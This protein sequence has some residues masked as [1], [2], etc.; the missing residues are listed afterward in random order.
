MKSLAS[1]VLLGVCGVW[2]SAR[3]LSAQCPDGT[4]PPCSVRPVRAAPAPTSVAVLPFANLSRDSSDAYLAEGLTEE[5]IS[6]LG[7]V[8]RLRVPGRSV[9]ERA[10]AADADPQSLA[11]RLGVRYLV[12]GSVRRSGRRLRVSVR[13]L[14]ALDGVRVWGDDYD[15]G[16]EDLLAVQETIAREV[17]TNVAGQLLPGE[18]AR[19]AALPTRDPVAWDHYLRGN[20]ALGARSA[21]SLATA[22]REYDRALGLDSTFTAAQARIAYAYVLGGLY[23]LE[24]VPADSVN[25]HAERAAQRALLLDPNS[26]DAWLAWGWLR[27]FANT[28]SGM[29]E[30]RPPWSAP[31]A[32]TRAT[33]KRITNWDRC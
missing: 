7:A 24:G 31:C 9:V 11:R 20:H 25:P 1:A 16:Q 10:R 13:L 4:P 17:A 12:E 18:Q 23:G 27:A 21:G 19:L 32:S 2:A 3:W 14:R 5:L 15:R 8:R 26:S 29:R 30:A 28:A 6:R 22:I 33:P